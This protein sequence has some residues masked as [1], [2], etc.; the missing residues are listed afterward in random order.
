MV[1][2][3]IDSGVLIAAS[4][5]EGDIAS[6][7]MTVLTDGDRTFASSE[8]VK[9]EVLPK[10]IYNK[11]TAESAFY[12]AFFDAVSVW[13]NE[14]GRIVNDAYR[15]ASAYGIAAMDALHVAAALQVDAVELVTT[16]RSSKPIHRVPAIRVIS[17][18]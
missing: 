17:I 2:T 1:L 12:D 9:L 16:E 3:F 15:L 5:G 4:R 10:A 13:S 14:L 7:A 6:R 11:Q 18:F 8:F